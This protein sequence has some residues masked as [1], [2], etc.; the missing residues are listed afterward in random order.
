MTTQLRRLGVEI[1]EAPDGATIVGGAVRAGRVDAEGDHRV[2][3]SL[4]V[5][6][7]VAEG[8]IEIEGADWIATSYPGFVEDLISLGADVEVEG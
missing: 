6:G 8:P 3:M 5:L 4:A 7:L 1:E 2:A